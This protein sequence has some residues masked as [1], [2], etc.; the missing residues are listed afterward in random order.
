[1]LHAEVVGWIVNLG[2]AGAVIYVVKMFIAFLAEQG[3]AYRA[4]RQAM[5]EA[6]AAERKDMRKAFHDTI[7][8]LVSQ[9]HEQPI[10]IERLAASL[11]RMAEVLSTKPCVQGDENFQDAASET[12]KATS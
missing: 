8:G 5:A 11:A 9:A 3:A 2:A 1:M 4:E 10:A 12:R 6:Y 7:E